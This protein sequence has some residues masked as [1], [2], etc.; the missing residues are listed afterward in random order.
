MP[1]QAIAKSAEQQW[2]DFNETRRKVGLPPMPKPRGSQPDFSFDVQ[3]R[4]ATE[5]QKTLSSDSPTMKR[6][7]R[8]KLMCGNAPKDTNHKEA[9][10]T[11]A[12]TQPAKPLVDPL[13]NNR[14]GFFTEFAELLVDTMKDLLSEVERLANRCG[15]A[16]MSSSVPLLQ[17]TLSDAACRNG[18]IAAVLDELILSLKQAQEKK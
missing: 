1:Q 2:E 11:V 18:E 9:V 7:A 16:S 10:S 6:L 3:K 12:L 8:I 4:D 17:E 5:V 14:G 15:N 13:V